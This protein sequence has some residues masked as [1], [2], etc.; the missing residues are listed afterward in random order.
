MNRRTRRRLELRQLKRLPTAGVLLTVV[1]LTIVIGFVWILLSPTIVATVSLSEKEWANIAALTSAATLAVA[2]GAGIILLIELAET[3]DSRNLEIYRDIYERLM[4]DEQIDARRFIY[5]ELPEPNPDEPQVVIDAV[6]ASDKAR[7]Q[8]KKVLNL[9]DYFGFLIDQDWVTADEIIGWLS[10]V[11]VKVWAKI[12]PVV[13][14]EREQRPEEPDYYEA[15]TKLADK[16]RSWR[17]NNYP[18]AEKKVSFVP[19]RL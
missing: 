2:L 4:S 16:C 10:P 6:M 8:V 13:V 18:E 11:V 9:I 1:I 12:G 15:A 19:H 5:Q 7:Y 17:Q 3:A 14:Y